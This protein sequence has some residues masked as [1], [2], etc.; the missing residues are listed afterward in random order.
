MVLPNLFP[1]NISNSAM[2]YPACLP[3]VHM[4]MDPGL[5]INHLLLFHPA[6]VCKKDLSILCE[7]I[8]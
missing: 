5:P 3:Y 1:Y 7:C 2:F 8:K 6:V 4:N